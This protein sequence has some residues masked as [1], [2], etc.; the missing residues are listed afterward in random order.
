MDNLGKF[1]VYH[2]YGMNN[3][4]L[5]VGKGSGERWKH[6]NSGVSSNKQLNRYYFQNG[7][8]DCIK[9]QIKAYFDT[10]EEALHYEKAS[11]KDSKPVTTKFPQFFV[12]NIEF[13]YNTLLPTPTSLPY[14]S[15]ILKPSNKIVYSIFYVYTQSF[16]ALVQLQKHS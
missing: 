12:L 14:I 10:E 7:E 4:L 13:S 6:C 8:G 16:L 9:T 15:I 3:E 2:A 1:Y 5:Y 11:I